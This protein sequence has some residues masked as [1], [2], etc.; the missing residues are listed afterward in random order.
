MPQLLLTRKA[1]LGSGLIRAVSWSGV[2]HVQVKT[3][4]TLHGASFP[5]GVCEE[6]FSERVAASSVAILMTVPAPDPDGGDAFIA[7]NR[8]KEY[9]TVG[10]IGLALHQD[11][12]TEG[13]W[14]CSSYVVAYLEAC[15]TKLF[16]EGV[17][18][19]VT[20]QHIL[21]LP[22]PIEIIR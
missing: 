18:R 17:I 10:A 6:S 20:P 2:S 11:W 22:L 4:D 7:A 8:G 5:K 14:W 16:R 12:Q 3:G 21:M 9:D 15:G 1:H 19:R 13:M